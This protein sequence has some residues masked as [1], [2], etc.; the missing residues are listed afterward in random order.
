MVAV[1]VIVPENAPTKLVAVIVPPK[2]PP[3]TTPN[4]PATCKAPDVVD[5]VT[6]LLVT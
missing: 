4:P 3:P 2:T 1:P 5:V 6:V